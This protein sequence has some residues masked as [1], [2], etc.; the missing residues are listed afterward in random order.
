MVDDECAKKAVSEL[1][2]RLIHIRPRR[3][4]VDLAALLHQA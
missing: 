3:Q 4:Y 1:H 2:P